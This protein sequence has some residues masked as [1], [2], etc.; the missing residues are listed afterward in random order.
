[1][2]ILHTPN[3]FGRVTPHVPFWFYGSAKRQ[4][5]EEIVVPAKKDA[6]LQATDGTIVL[7]PGR[8]NWES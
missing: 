1:M 2:D 6:I 5:L 7:T 8:P 3:N 4:W